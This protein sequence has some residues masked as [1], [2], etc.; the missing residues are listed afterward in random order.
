MTRS[1]SKKR[2]PWI[3]VA[4]I[5]MIVVL[6]MTLTFLGSSK[7]SDAKQNTN[8]GPEVKKDVSTIES[9][10][11]G[12][13]ITTEVKN[14]DYSP[15]AIQYPQS[16]VVS[17]NDRVKK[18]IDEQRDNY[19]IAME[20]NKRIDSTTPGELNIAFETFPHASGSY[21]LVMISGTYLGGA[22]G[23]NSF[24]TIHFDPESGEII[25]IAD[26]FGHDESKLVKLSSLVRD[27][28]QKDPSLTNRVLK[29]DM[30]LATEPKWSNFENFA[31][32][33]DSLV[34]YFDEYEIASGAAGAP[35]I[36]VPLAALTEQLV[37]PYK[38]DVE[39]V[40]PKPPVEEVSDEAGE[41]PIEEPDDSDA[42]E[43]IVVVQP[44]EKGA[45][46]VALTFDDGPDP[47]VTPQILAT[48]AKY[49]AKATFFMLGSRV[50]SY[51]EIANDVLTAGHEL[52]NHTWTHANLTNMA[53]DSIT[54][55]VSRTNNII[56]QATGQAPTVFRPP[57]G[58]FNDDI[59]NELQLP[60]VLWDVD[61]LDWKHRDAAQLLTSVKSSVH[62]GSNVLMHDIHLSTAQGLDSVLAYL[63]SEGYEFVT[64]SEL[65]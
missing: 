23:F 3:D 10:F 22:N 64:V 61:T 19:L 12:I 38:L 26:L 18:Y 34:L 47:K 63:T 65:E 57:Y 36:A 62:D 53:T 7:E 54:K 42:S 6:S 28:I 2:G 9:A 35:V 5:S 44:V 33:D 1:Q 41:E 48:L 15:Y 32:I 45:K 13:L 46:Q 52:G 20:E 27:G 55:E 17:F 59:L 58:A 29:E 4:C 24:N 39:E 31:L 49:D 51:P 11:P 40:L 60:V 37:A 30:M 8:N 14:D 21:S 50:E 25:E 43:N 56:E 16:K